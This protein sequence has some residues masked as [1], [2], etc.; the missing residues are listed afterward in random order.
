MDNEAVKVEGVSERVLLKQIIIY[1]VQ[2]AHGQL[3]AA[4]RT[5]ETIEPYNDK[6]LDILERLERTSQVEAELAD[7]P[8]RVLNGLMKDL[9]GKL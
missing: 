9:K 2:M 3:E 5:F 7:I 6:A 8:P 4:E 1:L